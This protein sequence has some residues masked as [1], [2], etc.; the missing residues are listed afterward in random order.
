MI[1]ARWISICLLLAALAAGT[2]SDVSPKRSSLVVGG[3]RVLAADFHVH[4]FPLSWATLS[5][6]NTVLEARRHGLDVIA[7]T[8]HNHVWVSKVGRWFSRLIGGP[9]ILVSEEIVAP[10]YHILAVGI[11]NTISWRQRAAG[12]IDEVHRQGGVAIA[13]HPVSAYWRGYDAEAMRKLDAAEVLHPLAYDHPAEYLELQ[14]FF[15]RAR[16]TAIGDSDYHGLRPMGLCRTFVFA[17]ENSASAILEALRAGHTVV[18]DRDA[19]AFGDPEL[20]RLAA[21]EPRF[22]ELRSLPSNDGF[23]TKASR[24]CGILGILGLFLFGFG[25]PARTPRH[26]SASA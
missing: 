11:E 1:A 20:I 3:Y 26:A 9:T 22:A 25:V 17:R 7:M 8:P 16:L 4:S 5:P 21:Q 19:R 14:E 18:Y 6:W 13:A 10:R 12:A 15:G 2:I 23:L 24:V